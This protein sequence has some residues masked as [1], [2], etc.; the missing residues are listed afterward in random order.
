MHR[1][2]DDFNKMVIIE[3][4]CL[5]VR[6]RSRTEVYKSFKK[7]KT[8]G[9]C[10]SAGGC[11]YT[12]FQHI[13]TTICSPDMFQENHVVYLYLLYIC[14]CLYIIHCTYSNF[15]LYLNYI[16]LCYTYRKES[17]GHKN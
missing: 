9:V 8:R 6:H 12:A 10:R 13:P 1:P 17:L 11:I 4:R 16:V 14:V 15:Y 5:S 3:R 2:S 7:V